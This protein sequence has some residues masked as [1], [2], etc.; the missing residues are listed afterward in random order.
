MNCHQVKHG[1]K[2]GDTLEPNREI[3]MSK[4]GPVYPPRNIWLMIHYNHVI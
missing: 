1:P 2:I 4:F 3:S